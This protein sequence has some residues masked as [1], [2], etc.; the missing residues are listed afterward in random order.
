MR[1]RGIPVG[2]I[3]L[4]LLLIAANVITI[5]IKPEAAPFVFV[6]SCFAFPFF[7]IAHS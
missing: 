3:V 2:F 5:G 4:L 1:Q 7:L 6:L